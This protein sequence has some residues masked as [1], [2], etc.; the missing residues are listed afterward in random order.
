MY[1]K[2]AKDLYEKLKPHTDKVYNITVMKGRQVSVDFK[3]DIQFYEVEQSLQK[4][5]LKM[6]KP[7]KIREYYRSKCL[8]SG[9]E[10]LTVELY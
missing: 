6:R 7:Y 9:Q 5:C 2:K 1:T 10:I 3:I 8:R 4:A